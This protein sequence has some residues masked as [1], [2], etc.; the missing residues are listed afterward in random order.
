VSGLHC[1]WAVEGGI[2]VPRASLL[3][4]SPVGI[5][6]VLAIVDVPLTQLGIAAHERIRVTRSSAFAV[7]ASMAAS[8]TPR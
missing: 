6:D 1:R 2:S 7:V 5:D 3:V 8:S 4:A